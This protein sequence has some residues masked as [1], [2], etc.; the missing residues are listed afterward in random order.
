M[1]IPRYIYYFEINKVDKVSKRNNDIV[2]KIVEIFNHHKGRY[3]VIK[4]I[5]N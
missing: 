1:D 5:K 2:D 4:Y 3:G